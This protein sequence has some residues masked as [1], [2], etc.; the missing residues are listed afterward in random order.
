MP[1]DWTPKLPYPYDAPGKIDTPSGRARRQLLKT[2]AGTLIVAAAGYFGWTKLFS[3]SGN[4]NATRRT[5]AAPGS[6]GGSEI[7]IGSAAKLMQS[8]SPSSVMVD[9]QQAFVEFSGATPRVLNATCPHQG[10]NVLWQTDTGKFVCPCHNSQF[11]RD[12]SLLQ[13]PSKEPLAQFPSIVRN[14][15]VYV[16]S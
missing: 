13:G 2:A 6:I 9:G 5:G 3:V 7:A 14:G 1:N 12:G 10:C 11:A 8:A 16:E 4:P 15:I